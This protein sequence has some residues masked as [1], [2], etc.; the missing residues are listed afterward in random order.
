MKLYL[1]INMKPVCRAENRVYETKKLMHPGHRTHNTSLLNSNNINYKPQK[2]N[3]HA[4]RNR[5]VKTTVQSLTF[6][7]NFFFTDKRIG[8]ILIVKKNL[9]AKQNEC[10]KSKEIF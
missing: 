3:K 1:K 6:Q 4:K 9:L 5:K 2:R 8:A 7:Q 10:P